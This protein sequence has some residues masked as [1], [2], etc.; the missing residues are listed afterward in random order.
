L[1]HNMEHGG[2]SLTTLPTPCPLVD[3][4]RLEAN[5]RTMSNAVR[6]RSGN[7]APGH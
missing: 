5:I 3:E 7:P 2:H 1:E 6:E 4:A